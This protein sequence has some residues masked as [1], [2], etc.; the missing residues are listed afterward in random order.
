MSAWS[1]PQFVA[2]C[3]RAQLARPHIEQL[4]LALSRDGQSCEL[5]ASVLPGLLARLGWPPAYAELLLK[6]EQELSTGGPLS[7]PLVSPAGPQTALPGPHPDWPALSPQEEASPEKTA[8]TY[9]RL[10]GPVLLS[11]I[12]ALLI[13]RAVELPA[14]L[15]LERESGLARALGLGLA[16]VAML[17]YF[18]AFSFLL[19]SALRQRTDGQ[20]TLQRAAALATTAYLPGLLLGLLSGNPL[21]SLILGSLGVILLLPLGLRSQR[22]HAWGLRTALLAGL[23]LLLGLGLS[24]FL[25]QREAEREG[26]LS[27]QTKQAALR[28]LQVR[29]AG[30]A[31]DYQHQQH[32]TGCRELEGP[33]DAIL[34]DLAER[35][36]V[37]GRV[38]RAY[39][40]SR[41]PE[42][43][44]ECLAGRLSQLQAATRKLMTKDNVLSQRA[45]DKGIRLECLV[46]LQ[47]LS[48]TRVALSQLSDST[49][50]AQ[51]QLEDGEPEQLQASMRRLEQAYRGAGSSWGI[52]L[53]ERC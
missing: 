17:L 22:T 10:F 25:Q 23:L 30:P 45:G 42:C 14:G 53:A 31:P 36:Q 37:E 38:S 11:S 3:A 5:E 2:I 1:Y 18:L 6:A 4:W 8:I 21:L 39:Q 16:G 19:R 48:H 47:Y 49:L 33:G 34:R 7:P 28:Y 12:L 32:L 29:R 35:C 20:L 43:V 51:A 46:T 13:S 50:A 52:E 40:L 9:R 15:L 27:P 44:R 24:L 41:Q 26:R